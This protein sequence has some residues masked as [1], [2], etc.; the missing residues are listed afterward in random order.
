MFNV[1]LAVMY[2]RTCTIVY[3]D[4]Q[5]FITL[6]F[7]GDQLTV[8]RARSGQKARIASDTR[9]EALEGLKPAAADWHAEAN[10]LQVYYD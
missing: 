7:F 5:K 6:M 1:L 3:S 8:Q 9:E 10:F 2:L 4:G